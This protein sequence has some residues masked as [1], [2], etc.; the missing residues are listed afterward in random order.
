L[1]TR[2]KVHDISIARL[3]LQR[4]QLIPAEAGINST[5]RGEKSSGG[6]MACINQ[7]RIDS[8]QV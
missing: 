2:K 6:T 5:I 1:D 4:N 3:D 7:A 8:A